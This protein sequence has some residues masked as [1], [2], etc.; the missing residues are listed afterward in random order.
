MQVFDAEEDSIMQYLDTISDKSSPEY[1]HAMMALKTLQEVKKGEDDMLKAS[2][3]SLADETRF[4]SEMEFKKAELE[5]RERLTTAENALREREL[6]LK[7]RQLD[8]DELRFKNE[9]AKDVA[10][11]ERGYDEQKLRRHMAW[12]DFGKG[13]LAMGILTAGTMIIR[14]GEM[15]GEAVISSNAK[16]EIKSLGS[17]LLPRINK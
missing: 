17:N 10:E 13:M 14:H 5:Q 9:T 2:M 4:N 12:M 1:G 8:L 16:Q 15:T 6:A 11:I 7:E 3:K